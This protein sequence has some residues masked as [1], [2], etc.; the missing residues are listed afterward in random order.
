MNGN[1]GGYC[2]FGAGGHAKDLIAQISIDRGVEAINCLVDDFEPNRLVIGIETLSFVDARR[3]FADTVWLVAVGDS[4]ARRAISERIA[5]DGGRLG[6]FVSTRAVV[7][8]EFSPAPG[9]Q[10]LSGCF[11]SADVALGPGV[12]L[13]V[14][15]S[16]SHDGKIGSYV[17]I[18]PGCSLAGRVILGND[19]FIGA[20]ATLVSD[21][22]HSYLRVGEAATVGAGAVVIADVAPG[23][24]VVGVPARS[25]KRPQC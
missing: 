17:T 15:S 11:I 7:G 16:I 3:R 24:T 18:S 19:V 14:N 8:P 10:V 13:N 6:A 5:L 9:V 22:P 2:I 25:L 20:G 4:K 23:D 1:T 21:A 12:I